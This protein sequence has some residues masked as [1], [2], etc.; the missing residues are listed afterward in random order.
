M[1]SSLFLLAFS[2]SA[3]VMIISTVQQEFLMMEAEREASSLLFEL[4]QEDM[5]VTGFF[6]GEMSDYNGSAVY[7]E[8][9]KKFCLTAAEDFKRQIKVCL[10][11][12]D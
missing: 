12:Y 5:Q 8:S 10:P 6:H 2:L 4:V 7:N 9:G 11:A 3:F 1:S